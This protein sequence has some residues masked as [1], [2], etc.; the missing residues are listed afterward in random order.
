MTKKIKVLNTEFEVRTIPSEYVTSNTLGV[1]L[2][3]E[4]IIELYEDKP[5]H[6]IHELIHAYL[7]EMGHFYEKEN[8]IHSE[9]N[10]LIFEKVIMNMIAD[11]HIS[12]Y[13]DEE[14]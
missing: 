11:G 2:H 4:K 6:L 14:K 12:N 5:E 7:I 3:N 9:D 1:C 8:G 10:V 13:F